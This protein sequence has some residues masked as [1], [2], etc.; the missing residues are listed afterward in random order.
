VVGYLADKLA[1]TVRELEDGSYVAEVEGGPYG[2]IT[3]DLAV[4]QWLASPEGE[5]LR[6]PALAGDGPLLQLVRGMG[7][8]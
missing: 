7:E 1:P 3:V 6:P 4:E 8:S 2:P 5:K